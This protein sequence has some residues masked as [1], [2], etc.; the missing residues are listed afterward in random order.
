MEN[1]FGL[2][3][4]LLRCR[5]ARSIGRPPG[6]PQ[7]SQINVQAVDY[8]YAVHQFSS[9]LDSSGWLKVTLSSL[10]ECSSAT[11]WDSV[12]QNPVVLSLKY[13]SAETREDQEKAAQ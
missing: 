8:P 2:P 4:P 7:P 9:L 10:E 13:F 11:A 5:M 1:W 12:S 6:F 3:V